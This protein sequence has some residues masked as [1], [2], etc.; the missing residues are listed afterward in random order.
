MTRSDR[1]VAVTEALHAVGIPWVPCDAGVFVLLDLRQWCGGEGAVGSGAT[2][3]TESLLW[4]Q[5]L[6]GA[7]I[8]LTPGH[9][10][11]VQAPGWFRLCF[12]A[13]PT[14]RVVAAVARLAGVLARLVP[15]DRQPASSPV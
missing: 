2:V 4:Q 10:M 7:N 11:H 1:Y 15:S 8:N 13:A 12:A 5:I 9:A 6:D 14:K 3:H